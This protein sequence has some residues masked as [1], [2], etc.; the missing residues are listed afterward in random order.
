[1]GPEE[2]A[3][4]HHLPMGRWVVFQLAEIAA[5]GEHLSIVYDNGTEGIVTD[6]CFGDRFAH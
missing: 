3:D 4:C 6:L 5:F 1:M 2:L